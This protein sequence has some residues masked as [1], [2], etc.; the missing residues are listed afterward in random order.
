MLFL[1]IVVPPTFG[2]DCARANAG[3]HFLSAVIVFQLGLLEIPAAVAY[4]RIAAAGF[5]HWFAR[6]VIHD[7]A[8][9]DQA[10][11]DRGGAFDYFNPVHAPGGV[12]LS[13][14]LPVRPNPLVGSLMAAMRRTSHAG[15]QGSLIAV[16]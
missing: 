3:R 9:S 5:E 4:S 11:E 16:N 8:R 14:I 10:E 15:F 2:V 6:D 12:Q 1:E 13:S 7:S